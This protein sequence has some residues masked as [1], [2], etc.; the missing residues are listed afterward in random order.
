M[1]AVRDACFV[2][3]ADP[4]ALLDTVNKDL[5]H[6]V[7]AKL[8]G[9]DVARLSCCS[10]RFRDLAGEMPEL[11]AKIDEARDAARQRERETKKRV[12]DRE[13]EM[14]TRR[15]QREI[16]TRRMQVIF[17]AFDAGLTRAEEVG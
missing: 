4:P 7:C 15:A 13:R 5:V 10:R 16:V 12:R 1:P 3:G 2:C 6:L 8:D 14:A 17:E 11:E 9:A